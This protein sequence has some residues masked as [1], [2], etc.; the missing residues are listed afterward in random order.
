MDYMRLTIAGQLPGGEVWSVNPTFQ[1][2]SGGAPAPTPSEMSAAVQAARS[3]TTPAPLLGLMS[4]VGSITRMRLEARSFAR[5]L[6]AVG[7]AA[8]TPPRAGVGSA[9]KPFQ[10][11]VVLSLRTPY[12]GGR[13]RGR[14]YWP[15]L[16]AAISNADL[17]IGA[18]GCQSIAQ[19]AWEYLIALAVAMQTSLN[20]TTVPTVVSGTAGTVQPVTYVE[21]GDVLDVQRRRR[22]KAVESRY[23]YPAEA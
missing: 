22:D 8:V 10:T 21:V 7:E 14:L 4:T 20:M 18:A 15:G 6:E 5:G 3:V 17:R 2:G 12:P 11:S 23:R 13:N 16:A 9:T 19:A 1:A